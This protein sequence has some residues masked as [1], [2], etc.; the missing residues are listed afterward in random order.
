MF[1]HYNIIFVREVVKMVEFFFAVLDP[2][3]NFDG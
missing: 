1:L 3:E 2:V